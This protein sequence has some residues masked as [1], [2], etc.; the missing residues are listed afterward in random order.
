M[1]KGYIQVYTG[2]SKGKTTAALGLG[3]RAV[4]RGYTVWMYQF[5]KGAPSGELDS[6][7]L[8]N[9]RFRVFRLAEEKKFFSALTG[10]EKEILKTRLQGELR[11]VIEAMERESCDLLIL[12]EIMG[13]IHAGLLT[14]AEVCALID[15][16][17][18]GMELVLTGRNAPRE[19]L[20]KADLVTEMCCIK[21][22]MDAG[23][24]ARDGIEK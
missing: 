18:P 17:P 21:H 2:D 10:M 8:L 19:L 1:E 24:S 14:V 15:C 11:Q 6:I 9:G 12:D 5:L 22:Y 7:S 16:K 3:L 13:T 23:V 20:E 4:G